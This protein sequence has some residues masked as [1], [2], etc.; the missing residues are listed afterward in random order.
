MSLTSLAS[1]IFK[2]RQK[3]L[4]KYNTAAEELQ[5]KV[6]SSLIESGRE[7]E[8]GR[9]HL[10][11]NTHNYEQFAQNIP[12]NTYEEMKGYI[13]RM[14]HGEQNVLWPGGVKWYAKSS[15]TTNDKSKFIPVS[16][17]GLH[18]IHYKGGFDAV[19]LYLANHPHSRIFDG[20]SLILGGSHSPNYNLPGSLVGDLSAIL[21]EN[22]NPL[23]N[24]V[25]VPKKE[26]ALL[27]DFEIKRDRIARETMNKNVTT[28]SGV[29]SWMLSVLVRVMELSEKK[30]LEEV[31]PNLEVFW[32]GGIAFTPY[33]Q[34]Y[35]Q[36]IT[37]S[38]M[39]YME[40][41]NASEGFFGLQSNPSDKSMLLMIDYDVFY[42]FIPMDEFGSDHPTVVPLW[43][44]E[45]GKNYA[46]LISTSCGLWRYMIG[47][48]VQFTSKDPYKFIIT[49]R[50][51]YFINAFGEELIMDNAEQGLAYACAKTGAQI[52]DYTAAP[53]YMDSNA[54]CRHQ[55]LIEFSKEP[56]NLD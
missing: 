2:P 47:D 40:T 35:E 13:D 36:L 43:G 42:E 55:W 23:A 5:Q 16:A 6:L 33:R 54:K 11:K 15:G 38:K 28:I 45:L 4:E 41:Y 1:F 8:Y 12:V 26:T 20:K 29:P 17:D 22:I 50:T 32:H 34:Q 25:R 21:I 27:S 37:S 31:W 10:L 19:A 48:T 52:L 3:E 46:M 39:N 14:R 56:D 53:V 18:R 49:G 30:H 44:V 24:W 7:T 9:N 51:K